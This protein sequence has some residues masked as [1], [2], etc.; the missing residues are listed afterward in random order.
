MW[1]FP[2]IFS[3]KKKKKKKSER[4]REMAGMN[5]GE[6]VEDLSK[7]PHIH[8]QTLAEHKDDFLLAI[9]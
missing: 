9:T 4:E 3:K 6:T 5:K 7:S 1:N 2:L 8:G